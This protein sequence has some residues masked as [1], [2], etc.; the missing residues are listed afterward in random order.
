[1]R[2][3]LDYFDA[4]INRTAAWAIGARNAMRALLMA[5]L[6]PV[7]RLREMEASA[8][9]TGRLALLEE[10]KGL[11]FGA[12]WDYYCLTQRVPVGTTLLGEVRSYEERVLSRRAGANLG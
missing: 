5:L 10:L 7:A 9:Y 11:P 2:I 8:N 12:V 3:C 1:V 6:E 4:S